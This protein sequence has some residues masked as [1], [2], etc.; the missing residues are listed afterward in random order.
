[1]LPRLLLLS[2]LL[3]IGA[4]CSVSPRQNRV[5]PMGQPCTIGNLVYNAFEA[6][7]SAALGGGASGRVPANRFLLLRLSVLNRADHPITV[8]AL[9][10]I[11]DHGIILNEE[12]SGKSVPDWLG[13]ARSINPG[14]ANQG[15]ILFDA[16][17][18]HYKLRIPDE[19]GIR[20]SYIDVPF[21]L[22]SG[23]TPPSTKR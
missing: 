6:N 5:Y 1:M 2:L 22:S 19:D 18:A 9:A 16:P 20:I 8:P 17:P 14:S 15:N 12:Q 7:W 3:L 13:A 11:D 21:H 23:T 10:L 4:G